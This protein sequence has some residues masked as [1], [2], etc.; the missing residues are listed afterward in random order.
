M[1][2]RNG[3][4]FFD[5]KE[6]CWIA[7][8]QVTDEYGRRRNVKRRA[9]SKTEAEAKLK[10]LLR[11]IDDEGSKVVD[12]AQL[13]F[14]DLADYYEKRYLH[15]AV[16]VDGH[17]ISGLRDVERP[18]EFLKHFRA[19]FGKKKLREIS[20]GDLL[21]YRDRRFKVF[22]PR[23]QQR[24]I[25][26]WNREAAVLKRIFNI[27]CQQGY[28]LANPFHKGDHLII[29]SAER[30]RERVLT[31]AEEQR[32]LQACDSHPY[33]KHL[34]SFL[35]FLIDTGC[36]KSE[37]TQLRWKS[38]C[39]TS[40]LI[41]IEGMTTKTLKTRQVMM[42]ERVYKELS[43]LWEASSKDFT[44]RVFGITDNVR[45]SFAS[46]CE[47]AG[48]KHGGIDGLTLHGLRHTCAMRLVKSGM[49]P[50]L[51]G[52][53]LGHS[54]VNTTYKFYLTAD[55]E[56]MAQAAAI[57]EAFQPEPSQPIQASEMVN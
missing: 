53:L 20:Y 3:Y 45:H 33:R 26:S 36:R 9:K 25:G 42:T 48:I 31:V 12:Y 13:T 37:A 38:V 5:E 16:Y 24:T 43:E 17:K 7:R 8:T 32:L 52:K 35:I 22:T 51:A 57:L 47:V 18:K 2:Q 11:Q 50:Q 44:E 1:R 49:S 30:K 4:V 23:K 21:F 34:K 19:F 40:K 55:T 15:D 10:T 46:V 39:F 41:T 29:V 6:N 27:G 14:N 54:Q 28:L 56:T